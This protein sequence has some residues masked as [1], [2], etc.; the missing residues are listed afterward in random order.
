MSKLY[1]STL[2]P[3]LEN[4]LCPGAYFHL[5]VVLND[6]FWGAISVHLSVLCL[7]ND[8]LT[9]KPTQGRRHWS[10]LKRNPNCT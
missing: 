2:E 6:A 10:W 3:Y 8:K 1:L 5:S 7:D 4:T 9:V